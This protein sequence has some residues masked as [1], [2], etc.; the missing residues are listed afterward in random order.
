MSIKFIY[1]ILFFP[2]MFWGAEDEPKQPS[3]ITQVASLKADAIKQFTPILANKNDRQRSD[4]LWGVDQKNISNA[5]AP[6][7]GPVELSLFISYAILLSQKDLRGDVKE[8]GKFNNIFFILKPA[9]TALMQ[10]NVMSEEDWFNSGY[11]LCRSFQNNMLEATAAKNLTVIANPSVFT[12]KVPSTWDT[13]LGYSAYFPATSGDYYNKVYVNNQ[14]KNQAA[15]EAK[16]LS[17]SLPEASS[18][19][20]ELIN[21][22]SD[23]QKEIISNGLQQGIFNDA[24]KGN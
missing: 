21:K 16:L 2:L 14:K 20:Y 24:K 15:I 8:I 6:K 22:S 19:Y 1:L 4:L 17:R 18:I 7:L 12:P 5:L 9:R 13:V 10:K 3:A 23:I 11:L